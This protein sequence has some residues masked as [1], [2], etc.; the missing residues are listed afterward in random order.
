MKTEEIENMQEKMSYVYDSEE[1]I[2]PACAM[3]AFGLSDEEKIINKIDE[4]IADPEDYEERY[5]KDYDFKNEILRLLSKNKNKKAGMYV[6]LNKGLLNGEEKNC[7]EIAKLFGTCEENVFFEVR[8]WLANAKLEILKN[9]SSISNY[10]NKKGQI[11]LSNFDK[12]KYD[13]YWDFVESYIDDLRFS[14]L[15]KTIEDKN[16]CNCLAEAL[17]NY[18]CNQK[19][20]E[21]SK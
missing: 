10:M 21:F 17:T 20:E 3:E 11:S 8:N 5:I 4:A 16:R 12:P 19:G 18:L 14:S 9:G 2:L 1:R 6:I 13:S 7:E 15:Y